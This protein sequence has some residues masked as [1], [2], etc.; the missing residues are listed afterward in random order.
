MAE[1]IATQAAPKLPPREGTDIGTREALWLIRRAFEYIWPFRWRF[2]A[3]WFFTIGG[4]LPIL[5][6]P[7]P[8]K[9][10]IDQVIRGRPFDEGASRYPPYF[11][12]F[13]DFIDGTAPFEMLVWVTLLG[14]TMVLLVG[15]FGQGGGASD[16]TDAELAE[17]HDN[18]TRTENEAN[19][20]FSFASGLYGL[21]EFR[22]QL[23]LSQALNH[24][25]RSRL[26]ERIKTLPMV[27][28]DDQRIGDTVYRVMYD[29]PMITR[30]CYDLT[31][32]PTGTITTFFIIVWLM[33]FSFGSA[34]EIVYLAAAV[35]PLYFVATLPFSRLARRR[36]LRS[37]T[38]GSTTTSILE[39]GMSNILAVQSLGGWKRERERFDEASRAS[40]KGYLSVMWVNVMVRAS[41]GLA[42]EIIVVAIFLVVASNIIDATFSVGDYAVLFFYFYWMQGAASL[43][44]QMWIRLQD[45]VAGV[46]R[47][48]WLMDLPSE[49]DEGKREMAPIRDGVSIEHATLV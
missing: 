44:A 8:L 9:I 7:W 34:P 5:Y 13:I 48:F 22:W 35:L 30:L 14:A 2:V 49:T 12:P 20:A 43:L 16:N 38:A 31:L 36:N 46:R 15:T 39:E 26:F 3:K 37:R 10:I 1:A 47:V 41:V 32:I 28:L 40:F 33:N 45:N 6:V 42:R 23:R 29:T 4:V 19:I 24:Y 18:A 27:T 21:I 17:G 25:Y 11:Q